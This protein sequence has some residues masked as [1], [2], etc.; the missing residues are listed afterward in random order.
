MLDQHDEPEDEEKL[1]GDSEAIEL[2][3]A[4]ARAA[5]VWGPSMRRRRSRGTRAANSETALTQDGVRCRRCWFGS[6][7]GA[8]HRRGLPR[9]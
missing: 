3:A 4:G 7:Q 8:P 2:Y 1:H 5:W 6:C 9:L